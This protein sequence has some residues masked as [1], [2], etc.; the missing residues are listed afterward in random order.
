M[1]YAIYVSD[2]EFP[3]IGDIPNDINISSKIG[4]AFAIVNWTEPNA[5]DNSGV[6]TV[7][8]TNT[9][10]S[11]FYIGTTNVTYTAIDPSGNIADSTFHVKVKGQCV[12]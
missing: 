3:T 8:S 5:T 10:G 6:V 9:P 12:D 7:S 11:R 1:F 4:Q 2:E